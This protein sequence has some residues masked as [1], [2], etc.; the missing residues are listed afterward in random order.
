[1]AVPKK[2][3]EEVLAGMDQAAET[4]RPDFEKI[5]EQYPEAVSVLKIWWKANFKEAGHKRLAYILMD[6]EI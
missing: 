4:A 6:M 1:M 2:S 5:K 3:K